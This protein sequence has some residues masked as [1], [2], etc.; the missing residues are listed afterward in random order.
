M[1]LW[2]RPLSWKEDY[3]LLLPSSDEH[4][5]DVIV[6]DNDTELQ[7]QQ[8]QRDADNMLQLEL[9]DDDEREENY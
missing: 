7:Q 2:Y 9:L 5:I 1:P 6:A 4:Y 8:Q 3:D